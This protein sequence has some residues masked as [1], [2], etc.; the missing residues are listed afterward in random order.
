MYKETLIY[1]AMLT[2]IDILLKLVL[3]E[4]IARS[5]PWDDLLFGSVRS[6]AILITFVMFV[7]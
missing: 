4:H 1:W 7:Q 5:Q 2:G 3:P 6:L